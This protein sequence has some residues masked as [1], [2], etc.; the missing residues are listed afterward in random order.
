MNFSK[1]QKGVGMIE[2]LVAL[3]ILSVAV[4]GFVGLQL[5]AA[6]A[7]REAS[8][9]ILAMNVARDLAEKIRINSTQISTY[10]MQMGSEESQK[11]SSTNC[12]DTYCT[13]AQKAAFDVNQSYLNALAL[14]MSINMQ[15]C[16]SGLNGKQCIYVAWGK[17]LPSNSATDADNLNSC[18]VS[19]DNGFTY[20][21]NSTCTVME[22]F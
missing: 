2:V 12:F 19:S 6:E 15:T 9:R 13:A 11:S 20:R 10:T 18:T 4:L 3:L 8:N 16:P 17:T 5:R 14:G 22:V 1:R 7:G 21:N